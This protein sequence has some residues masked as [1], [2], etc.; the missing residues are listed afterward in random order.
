MAGQAGRPS[1]RRPGV[2]TRR[3]D[4]RAPPVASPPWEA[5]PP[6]CPIPTPPTVEDIS[7]AALTALALA[8]DPDAAVGPDAV[9]F[10]TDQGGPA[11]LPAWYMAVPL[12]HA[13]GRGR[14]LVLAGL[15][16]ALLVVNGAGLCV[17]NGFPEI[18]W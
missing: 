15:I 8:A 4:A 2:L 10:R 6:T 12:A 9:P 17:T 11:P 14:R 5:T 18:A 3:Y 16:G 7:D 1:G 13:G